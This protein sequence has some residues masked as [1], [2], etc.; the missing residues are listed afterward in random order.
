MAPAGGRRRPV[1][2]SAP[3]LAAPTAAGRLKFKWARR[4][5]REL[6][7]AT[8]LRRAPARAAASAKLH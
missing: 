1:G 3:L 7:A 6:R 2:A 5:G 4:G 8:R